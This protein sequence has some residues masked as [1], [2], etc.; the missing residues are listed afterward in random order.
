MPPEKIKAVLDTNIFVSAFKKPGGPSSLIIKEDW[1]LDRFVMVASMGTV[2]EIV[3]VL[4]A[5]GIPQRSIKGLVS[6]IMLYAEIVD[7]QR[8]DRVIKEHKKDDMFVASALAAKAHYIV[9]LNTRH[10]DFE[11]YD[12]VKIL[13]PNQFRKLFL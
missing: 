3:K 6:L 8:I 2:N 11:G 1:A 7:D 12:G 5:L 9:T 13:S 4:T 10:F